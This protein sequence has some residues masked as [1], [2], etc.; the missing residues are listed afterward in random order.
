MLQRVFDLYSGIDDTYSSQTP[1]NFDSS[2]QESEIPKASLSQLLVTFL[3]HENEPLPLPEADQ[4]FDHLLHFYYHSYMSSQKLLAFKFSR[5]GKVFPLMS[6]SIKKIITMRR[7]LPIIANNAKRKP[8]MVPCATR[9]K[10]AGITFKK[11]ESKSI[12][13][14]N[15]SNGVLTIP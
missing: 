14:V 5:P 13:N 12:F 3:Q 6:A 4:N 11:A 10:D 1:S 7:R 8:R 9:L 15:F 2:S